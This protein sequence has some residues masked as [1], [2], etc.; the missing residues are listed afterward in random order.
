M[1]FAMLAKTGSARTAQV[2]RNTKHGQFCAWM[3][4][5]N[6]LDW[7]PRTEADGAEDARDAADAGADMRDLRAP[8]A[9]S[10]R[11]CETGFYADPALLA[12]CGVLWAG[13]PARPP[14]RGGRR[15]APVPHQP[16]G[17]RAQWQGDA[18]GRAE[19]WADLRGPVPGLH[20]PGIGNQPAAP[21]PLGPSAP[22]PRAR[23]RRSHQEPWPNGALLRALPCPGRRHIVYRKG[24]ES[25][26]LKI[27]GCMALPTGK[28]RQIVRGCY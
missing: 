11:R 13:L 19:D 27:G 6:W 24:P 21:G 14:G 16:V 1:W 2:Q 20:L 23:L 5:M 10:L 7:L 28:H 17:C 9:L 4:W 3:H 22:R 26:R 18:A 15:Y 8:R 25:P 12:A